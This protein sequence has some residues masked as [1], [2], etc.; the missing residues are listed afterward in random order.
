MGVSKKIRK[1]LIDK[2]MKQTDL[3]LA[4]GRTVQTLRNMMSRDNMTYST[5]EGLVEAMDCELVIRDRKTGK[6]YD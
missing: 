4:T 1:A 6:I 2:D 5:V 3:A